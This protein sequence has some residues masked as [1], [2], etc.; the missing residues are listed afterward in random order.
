MKLITN[1]KEGESIDRVLKK[2]KQKFDKA[3]ILKKLRKRQH[4]I[5]P[6]ERKRK[7]L[8]KAK[9]REYINSKNYD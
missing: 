5:K 6:S 3:R 8:I 1:V 7:K 2:C 9:Y 4:Y